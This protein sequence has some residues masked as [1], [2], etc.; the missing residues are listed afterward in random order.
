MSLHSIGILD[1]VV[2][3]NT[4]VKVCSDSV[5][6]VD[7]TTWRPGNTEACTLN[8]SV[9]GSLADQTASGFVQNNQN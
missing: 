2:A 1:V 9:S 8:N 4:T 5:A 3:L 6:A 7:Y